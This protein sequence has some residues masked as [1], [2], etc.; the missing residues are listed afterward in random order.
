[1]ATKKQKAAVKKK[2]AMT[3]ESGGKEPK[4]AK[5]MRAVGYSARTARNPKKL[6]ESKGW[7]EL[8]E[9]YLPDDLLSRKL[10]EG[11]EANKQLATRPIFKKEAP[12]S[13][14]AGEVPLA[15]TGEFI[16]VPDMAVRHKYVETALKVKGK[17]VEKTD[18][19]TGGDKL[20]PIQ[21][22][23]TEDKIVTD[24]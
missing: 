3:V 20:E 21:I 5:V 11:L 14:S 6:T 12:T 4:I 2:I 13:Q 7:E 15:T 16:E 18:L 24:E 22:I 17:L 23:I 8:L 19:T 1:M 10:K 9:Q